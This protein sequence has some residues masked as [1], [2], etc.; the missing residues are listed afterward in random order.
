MPSALLNE[1]VPDYYGGTTDT[2]QPFPLHAQH[3]LSILDTIPKL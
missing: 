2:G 3:V 1:T